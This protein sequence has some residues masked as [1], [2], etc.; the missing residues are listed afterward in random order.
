MF[1][2]SAYLWK[3]SR[4]PLDAT[5]IVTQITKTL[6]Q[7]TILPRSAT[8]R[9]LLWIVFS[10]AQFALHVDF[11][12]INVLNVEKKI[13]N[14]WPTIKSLLS[15]VRVFSMLITFLVRWVTRHLRI[16]LSKDG[17]WGRPRCIRFGNHVLVSLPAA[18]MVKVWKSFTSSVHG[19]VSVH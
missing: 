10:D 18:W 7:C 14:P 17:S 9:V 8:N 1:W 4:Q 12:Q 19:S 11:C 15:R 13:R 16:V 3:L 6:P 2:G 5:V